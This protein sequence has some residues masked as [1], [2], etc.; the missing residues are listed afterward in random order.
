[1]K[2]VGDKLRD[3]ATA[4]TEPAALDQFGRSAFNRYYY[5]AYLAVRERLMVINDR[6]GKSPHKTLPEILS[7]SLCRAAAEQAKRLSRAGVLDT[8]EGAKYVR[9][10]RICAGSLAQMLTDAYEARR[11]A[12]Y[13]P[14]E[15]VVRDSGSL[16]L[17]NFTLRAAESWPSQ[18]ENAAAQMLIHWRKLGL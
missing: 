11:V 8:A 3:I 7:K 1:M 13:E 6:W 12:D 10:I 5:A 18:A 2:I 14:R 16:R 4:S 15:L 17:R 9:S